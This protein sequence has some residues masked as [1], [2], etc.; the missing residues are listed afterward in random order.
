MAR[1]QTKRIIFF[2]L[3]GTLHQQDLFGSYLRYLLRH[4]KLNL[5]LVIGT[6]PLVSAGLLYAGRSARWPMSLLLWSITFG[7]SEQRLKQLEQEFVALFR[8]SVVAFPDVQQRLQEYVREPDTEVWLVTGSPLN[9]VEEAYCDAPWLPQVKT[10][11]S[12]M[13]RAFGGR[14]LTL[15]C[16]AQEKVAQL[17]QRLGAPLQFYSGY[18]DSLLD[19]PVLKFCQHR[20]RVTADGQLKPLD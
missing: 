14:I 2:D 15:R 6:L 9:L 5:P 7:R 18:S 10:I 12:Q 11:G 1:H 16:L 17:E 3:D 20:F 8:A 13:S 19:D 4:L